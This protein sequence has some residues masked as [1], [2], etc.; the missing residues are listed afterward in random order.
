MACACEVMRPPKDLPPANSANLGARRA[1]SA[2]AACTVA[3]Q[4]GGGSGR[5]LLQLHVRE[6]EAQSRDIPG[7]ELRRDRRHGRV[8]HACA[9]AVSEHIASRGRGR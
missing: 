2:T 4:T 3:W 9:R 7:G 5:P 6:L 8:L 1:A